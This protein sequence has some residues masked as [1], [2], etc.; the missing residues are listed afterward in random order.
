M[1]LNEKKEEEF[2]KQEKERQEKERQEFNEKYLQ[3]E[4]LWEF[5]TLSMFLTNNPM[6]GM[7]N[8][9]IPAWETVP[10]GSNGV[11]AGVITGITKKKTKQDKRQYAFIQVY[12]SYDHLMEC[13]CW[14]DQYAEYKDYIKTGN[15]VILLCQK[16]DNSIAI[17]KIKQYNEWESEG[18]KNG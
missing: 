15:V 1:L 10:D 5:N 8:D 17:S 3:D 6:K 12:S 7:C 11:I 4:F 2:N 13:A 18:K 16:R 14:A 9:R